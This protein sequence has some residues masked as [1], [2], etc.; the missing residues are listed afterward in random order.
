LIFS[1]FSPFTLFAI[2]LHSHLFPAIQ[3]HLSAKSPIS[4][5]LDEV[6]FQRIP[7][8]RDKEDGV[9]CRPWN[10]EIC[11]LRRKAG[12]GHNPATD[13]A[14]KTLILALVKMRIANAATES[15]VSGRKR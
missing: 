2:S 11:F 1:F 13:S 9:L 3:N 7:D 6:I 15:I 5:F 8:I 14:I 12:M 10:W 4:R